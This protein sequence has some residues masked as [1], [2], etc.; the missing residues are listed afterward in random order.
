MLLNS[1]R[2]RSGPTTTP[3]ACR[4][5]QGPWGSSQHYSTVSATTS[6]PPSSAPSPTLRSRGR[7]T[8]RSSLRSR[9][10]A[11]SSATNPTKRSPAEA[12]T[13]RTLQRQPTHSTRLTV[14]ARHCEVMPDDGNLHFSVHRHRGLDPSV[15]G[16]CRRHAGGVGDSQPRTA[17]GWWDERRA[18][19]SF[20]PA[21][22]R[23]A[24]A[25]PA[26]RG[27]QILL[28]GITASLLSGVDLIPLGF[29]RLRDIANAVEVFQVCAPGLQTDF[30]PLKTVD[31]TPGSLRLASTSFIGRENELLDLEGTLKT[32]QLITLTGLG[33]VGKTRL[34]LEV[35][36]RSANDFPDGVWVVELASVGDHA[37]V[38]NAAP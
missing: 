28:D 17:R 30:P 2:W 37:A 5:F 38:P 13:C 31:P 20:G 18:G 8:L 15:G 4:S 35:A 23:T 33:G 26:G 21:R 9:I 36:A 11:R 12:P 3:E 25:R 16:R 34:A 19:A 32:H 7:R 22:N 14:P 27:G 29:R 1:P 10:C 24:R 6:R